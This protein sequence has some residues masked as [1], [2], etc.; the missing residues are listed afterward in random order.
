MNQ[1]R[2][3]PGKLA[4]VILIV[5][6][7]GLLS[8]CTGFHTRLFEQSVEEITCKY[9]YCFVP[10]IVAYKD[11]FGDPPGMYD[12]GFWAS[13]KLYDTTINVSKYLS[14]DSVRKVDLYERSR[15]SDEY[16]ARTLEKVQM[17][18][19][20]LLVVKDSLR[21]VAYPDTSLYEPRDVN[22]VSYSFGRVKIPLD[23]Q[24][25]EA[26]F[27]FSVN[28]DVQMT[29]H[30]SVRY[31]MDRVEEFSRPAGIDA[32]LGLGADDDEEDTTAVE[33]QPKR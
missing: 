22:Y 29:L 19:L 21:I 7:L 23:V 18:S 12:N 28:Q 20:V 27:H 1:D 9:D 16:K 14:S 26:V 13:I 8:A 25:L 2:I 10:R 32:L 6:L 15:L 5:V 4:P 24:L 31:D 11:Y 3:Q 30:D 17:D 33:E